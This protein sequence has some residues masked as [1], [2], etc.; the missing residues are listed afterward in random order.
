LAYHIVELH[1]G[2]IEALSAGEGMGA[3]FTVTLPISQPQVSQAQVSQ[4]Q[5]S[6]PQAGAAATS[7]DNTSIDDASIDDASAVASLPLAGLQLLVVEDQA[8]SRDLLVEILEQHGAVVR[9][10]A[11]AKAGLEAVQQQPPN[12]MISD[13][14][15]LEED[16]YALI[17]KIRS[18]TPEQGGQIPAIALT[19]YSGEAEHRRVLA[20]GFQQ[21][22]V[23]PVDLEEL[24]NTV[25]RLT[26]LRN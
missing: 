10:V 2:M 14:G 7:L 21:Y 5:A 16:G 18:L 1:G 26:K 20:A 19:A 6:Q 4:P 3:T 8:D 23:K 17:A 13:I 15:M 11:S 24:V 9:A 12:L 25:T 22:L